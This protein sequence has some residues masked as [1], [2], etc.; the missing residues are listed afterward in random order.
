VSAPARAG[1][2]GWFEKTIATIGN[3]LVVGPS[4]KIRDPQNGERRLGSSAAG[5]CVND[6]S[7]LTLSTF[8]SCLALKGGLVGAMPARVLDGY[9]SEVHKSAT[10]TPLWGVLH[11]SPN[12]DQTPTDYWEFAAISMMLRGNHYARKLKE[13]ARL[14]GLEPVRPDIVQVRRREDGQIGYRWSWDGRSYDLTEDDVF[15]VRGF[16]GG[17]LGGLSTIGYARESLGNALAAERAAGSTFANGATP[18]GVLKFKDWLDQDKRT[19]ARTDIEDRFLGAINAGRPYILEGDSDWQSIQMNADDAQLLESR[20]WS[21][22]DICRWFGVPPILIGHSEKQSSWGTGVEQIVLGFLKFT[23]T[24]YLRRIEQAV[25]KQLLTPADRRQ[26]LFAEFNVEGLLRASSKE[27]AEF[28]RTMTQIGGM[29]INEVRRKE[30]LPPVEGGDVSRMQSQNA[31]I[32]D[33][34]AVANDA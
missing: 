11:E 34:P 21:V 22:E 19:Q 27:R 12:A 29:T 2:K 23:L 24:P 3:W 25:S 9:G 5:V 31:P 7:A 8:W 16:G 28:Y 17:P 13:G 10:D 4:P 30:K 18:S 20:A 15:H 26:G 1:S 14:I 33:V 6:Q 32:T